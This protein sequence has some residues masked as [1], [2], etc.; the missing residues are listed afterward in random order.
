MFVGDLGVVVVKHARRGD[1]LDVMLLKNQ[2]LVLAMDGVVAEGSRWTGLS[3]SAELFDRRL[4]YPGLSDRPGAEDLY[5]KGRAWA[6]LR[7]GDGRDRVPMKGDPRL[8]RHAA[9]AAVETVEEGRRGSSLYGSMLRQ[10]NLPGQG[11]G[12][13]GIK[14]K[15]DAGGDAA[16]G[17]PWSSLTLSPRAA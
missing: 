11:Q 14:A 5:A 12:R 16:K 8:W 9:W 10:A 7:G 2:V 15:S 17:R 4:E 1:L 3:K 6:A 13:A